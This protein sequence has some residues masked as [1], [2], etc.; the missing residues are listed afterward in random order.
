ML[1]L[2]CARHPCTGT[3]LIFSAS[4]QISRMIPKGNPIVV[5]LCCCL[6]RLCAR[7]LLMRMMPKG[8]FNSCMYTYSN[9]YLYIYIYMYIYIYIYVYTRY[10]C[11]YTYIYIYIY[12][13]V[14]SMSLRPR[15]AD[16]IPAERWPSGPG[17][18]SAPA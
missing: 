13:Y 16:A 6:L 9:T 14:S 5:C 7:A 11:I 2:I 18:C 3:L 8:M 1:V 15:A 12:T 4:F 10:M 17:T